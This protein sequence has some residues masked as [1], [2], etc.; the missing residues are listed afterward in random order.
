MRNNSMSNEVPSAHSVPSVP[1]NAYIEPYISWENG[2]PVKKHKVVISNADIS[3]MKYH[4][5][6]QVYQGEW[7]PVNECYIP[8]PRYNGMS[9]IEVAQHKLMDLAASGDTNALTQV[10]NRLIGLPKQTVESL[11][12]KG[13]LEDF[14]SNVLQNENNESNGFINGCITADILDDGTGGSGPSSLPVNSSD[15]TMDI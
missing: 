4:A 10:E 3:E 6:A 5:A 8:D 2:L 14:L 15:E 11:S 1:S 12:I 7:D 9:K 13:S